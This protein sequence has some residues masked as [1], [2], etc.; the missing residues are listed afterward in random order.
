MVKAHFENQIQNWLNDQNTRQFLHVRGNLVNIAF[1]HLV[2]WY[3]QISNE[4]KDTYGLHVIEKLENWK[5]TQRAIKSF[6]SELLNRQPNSKVELNN[7]FK[8]LTHPEHNI[9][10][11]RMKSILLALQDPTIEDV[12]NC[13]NNN[14]GVILISI[15]EK[16]VLNGNPRKMYQIDGQ[17]VPGAG[18]RVNGDANERMEAI[19]AE[20]DPDKHQNLIDYLNKYFGHLF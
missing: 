14:Y 8:Q 3:P 9:S 11:D 2:R 20:I 12:Q 7:L 5:I 4:G 1:H 19:G 18:L 17:L 16:N 10:V 15:E 6:M 13:L